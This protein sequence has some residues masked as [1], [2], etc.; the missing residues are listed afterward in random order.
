MPFSK[1]Q[2][3]DLILLFCVCCGAYRLYSYFINCTIAHC[4]MFNAYCIWSDPFNCSFWLYYSI[5]LY[6][7]GGGGDDC[8]VR[9]RHHVHSRTN[10]SHSESVHLCILCPWLYSMLPHMTMANKYEPHPLI[11]INNRSRL[12]TCTTIVLDLSNLTWMHQIKFEQTNIC[13]SPLQ[14]TGF[15]AIKFHCKH[16]L[17]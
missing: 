2:Q 9:L 8:C 5:L 16:W 12:I 11:Q 4:S 13:I 1:E 6:S 3:N 10:N 17:R 7:A 15:D 14:W